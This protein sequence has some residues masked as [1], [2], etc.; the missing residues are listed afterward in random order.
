MAYNKKT[1][2]ARQGL[3]LNKF[4]I[5]GA[6]PVPIIN[7]PDSVTQQG[8][9]LSAGNLNNLE[10]RIA[11]AFDDVEESKADKSTTDALESQINQQDARL[12]QHE[13]RLENLEQ[14]AGDYTTVQYRGTNAVPTGKAKNGLVEK[15][16]GKSRAWNQLVNGVTDSKSDSGIDFVNNGDGTITINGTAS[17][18]TS[19]RITAYFNF[20]RRGHKNLVYVYPDKPL[21]A[22]IDFY[23]SGYG[24]TSAQVAPFIVS[25]N[26]VTDYTTTLGIRI[27]Q[28]VQV[29]NI[30][31]RFAVYDLTLIFGAGNEPS[32]VADALA[33][34]SA[35][36]Q[37]NAYDAGSLVDTEVSGVESVGVNLLDEVELGDI[38]SSTGQNEPSS[39]QL[40]TKNYIKVNGGGTYYFAIF[41]DGVTTAFGVRQYDA[42]KNYIGTNRIDFSPN[43]KTGALTI[44][45][46]VAY[47]RVT[48]GGGYGT[49]FNNDIQICDNSLPD[50]IKTV[51]HPY[52]KS[53]LTLSETVKPRGV[54]TC[55]ETL[56]VETGV[57]DDGKFELVDLGSLDW[58][59]S[60][61]FR[62]PISALPSA[63]KKTNNN[64]CPLYKILG[65]SSGLDKEG[66]FGT[67]N[68][69]IKDSA[70]TDATTFKNAMS[71]VY[72]LYE[73]ATY[74]PSDP[75]APVLDNSIYT[76]GGGT[77]NTI[78]EQT[79]VIDN[80]LD[81][82]YL[83]V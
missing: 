15:I 70:Y 5:D 65:S 38:S 30:T 52:K 68:L 24:A 25:K 3:G 2:K 16:V 59:Y 33:Q 32:T 69:V 48:L 56:D 50:A 62:T 1:W 49:T 19:T 76:E 51:Y 81:V 61:G 73:K 31:M 83:T 41:S 39:S 54:G 74:T 27:S 66:Y 10:Q 67:S 43:S 45:A 55:V 4:S 11:D 22:G 12:N 71:G 53:T 7:Q 34:L 60:D 18:L 79:P 80:Y 37:Y 47:I 72:L 8:D 44:S 9:A 20:P 6:T 46:N 58:T 23:I 36:G 77:I 57:L 63:P 42:N 75:I 13:S 82:G 35:L 29:D 28:S 17:A 14:K 26:D 64:I 21:P 78:Q 40:R